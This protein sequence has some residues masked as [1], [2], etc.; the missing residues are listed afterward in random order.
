MPKKADFYT[1]FSR[2]GFLLEKLFAEPQSF[3]DLSYDWHDNYLSDKHYLTK[4][5]FNEDRTRI[6]NLFGISIESFRTGSNSFKYRIKEAKKTEN[7]ILANL[8]TFAMRSMEMKLAVDNCTDRIYFQS[9]FDDILKL[10]ALKGAIAKNKLVRIKHLKH[11]EGA[12]ISEHILAPWWIRPHRDH[13]YL[14]APIQNPNGKFTDKLYS[15]GLDRI[16]DIKILPNHFN[17]PKITA[18][19]YFYYSFGISTRPNDIPQ[20]ILLRAHGKEVKYI[21]KRPLHH[22]QQLIGDWNDKV[23]FADFS[24]CIVPSLEFYGH[25]QSRGEMLEVL[26]PDEVRRTVAAA[27]NKAAG[28]YNGGTNQSMSFS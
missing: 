7:A 6:Q 1:I 8:S 13:L 22:T 18:E 27:I 17:P 20:T 12:E 26:G 3:E 15:Y 23:P 4:S 9:Y 14:F 10:E 28:R 11:D 2:I 5:E 25:V 19:E 21:K 16:I 24:I